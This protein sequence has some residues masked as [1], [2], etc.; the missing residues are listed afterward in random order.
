MKKTINLFF[1]IVCIQTSL[2]QV[3]NKTI[4]KAEL[5]AIKNPLK[6]FTSTVTFLENIQN[7]EGIAIDSVICIDLQTIAKQL[8]NDS[9]LAISYN[10][11]S[12]YFAAKGK[13]NEEIEYLY[14]A[15]PLAEKYNDKRRI[16]S[17]YFDLYTAY[18]KL[19][20]KKEAYVFAKKGG[21]NLPDKTSPKY[22]F[23]LVQYQQKMASYFEEKMQLDS[24][25]FYAQLSNH[26]AEKINT[27]LKKYQTL[28]G[29]VSVYQHKKE[30]EIAMAYFRKAQRIAQDFKGNR[31]KFNFFQSYYW[32]L[33][34]QDSTKHASEFA[35]KMWQ[36]AQKEQN[37]QFILSAATAKRN[38]F[39]K[40][41]KIDSAYFYSRLETKYIRLI[42]N[43]E[44]L[45]GIEA[46]GLKEKL[47]KMNEFEIEAEVKQQHMKNIQYIVI[48]IGIITFI[49][50]YF[51][52]SN[53]TIFNEKW[54]SFF[55]ILGLLIVFEFINLITH[56]FLEQLTQHN[57]IVMLL[58]LVTL[59]SLLIPLHHRL[60]KW[61][62][63]K[64]TKKNINIRLAKAKKTIKVLEKKI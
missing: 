34:S 53:S 35:E 30:P 47:R 37:Q 57:P 8:K 17:I 64:M 45:S 44:K 43:Q 13:S 39:E 19:G 59:A 50:I 22:Y 26:T 1:F 49:I 58:A 36:I 24:A 33:V 28:L 10:W 61:I 56:P 18:F 48:F 5:T 16:S 62:K 15:L 27:N 6:R 12:A 54:I 41:N 29:L 55:G 42:Y 11:I 46:M 3:N 20:R 7:E 31:N 21:E 23:M 14:K 51:L 38:L 60:E 25:L 2:G 52:I 4:T 63:E 40:L 9:L 32:L